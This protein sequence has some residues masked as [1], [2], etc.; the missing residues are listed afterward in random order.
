[1]RRGWRGGGGAAIGAVGAAFYMN[2]GG[3]RPPQAYAGSGAG[4]SRPHLSESELA[5]LPSLLA[6]GGITAMFFNL[7]LA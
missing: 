7:E 5:I 1:M 4:F 6:K 3:G 2:G